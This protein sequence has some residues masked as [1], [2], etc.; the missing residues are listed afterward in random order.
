MKIIH[1]NKMINVKKLTVSILLLKSI[2]SLTAEEP[3]NVIERAEESG[4]KPFFEATGEGFA[5]VDG[6][7]Q[8]GERF[9]SDLNYGVELD[10]SKIA[11]WDG[12]SVV[13]HVET[14]SG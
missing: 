7:N 3:K 12:V 13:A 8:R 9:A 11:K 4:V 2:L 6:G 5:N 14:I 10:M 1:H